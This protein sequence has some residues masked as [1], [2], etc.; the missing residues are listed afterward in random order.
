MDRITDVPFDKSSSRKEDIYNQKKCNGILVVDKL[1]S[2]DDQRVMIAKPTVVPE[3]LL[4]PFTYVKTIH[5]NKPID[6][7]YYMLID[8]E[9]LKETA[10]LIREY[11]DG[12]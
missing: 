3:G 1:Q 11:D 2:I 7:L 5:D 6:T 8:K 10:K 12:K 9:T 4:I